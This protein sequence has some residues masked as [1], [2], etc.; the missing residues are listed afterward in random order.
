MNSHVGVEHETTTAR[1]VRWLLCAIV[2]L[3]AMVLG[4]RSAGE[5][6]R[7]AER[8]LVSDGLDGGRLKLF[9]GKSVVVK[10]ARPIKR[11]SIPDG[12]IAVANVVS[13][14]NVL[15]TGK[16]SGTSQ[17]VL[18]DEQ[19]RTQMIDVV[20][21][22]DIGALQEQY[23]TLF[24]ESKIEA[25]SANGTILLKGRAANAQ[26]AEQAV[27]L[28]APYGKVLNLIDVAGG[29]QVMLQVRFA[30][31]SRSATSA[32]GINLF[33][34][35][36]SF[37]GGSNIG[38][39]SPITSLL[40]NVTVGKTPAFNG[41]NLTDAH[42]ISPSV[43]LYGATQ[44]GNVYLEAFVEALRQNNLL[45]I[46]AE[47]NLLAMSGE[48]ASFLA[49][50]EFPIPIAQ[51]GAGSGGNTAITVQFKEF[52]VKL[53]F[54]PVVLGDGRIRLKVAP[55]VSDIDFTTAVK[56]NGFVIPGLS[57]RRVSTTIELAEG[58]TFAIAGLLNHTVSANKDATPLLG[59]LPVIGSLFRS[60]RYMRKETELVVLV[61]P[62]VVSA[63]NPGEVP[64]MPGE[65]WRHPKETDL[66]GKGDLGGTNG[67]ANA[68]APPATAP[69]FFGQHGFT[70]AAK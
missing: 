7:P 56:F 49:G 10:A 46:L 68:T 61:T 55:E 35:S 9:T 22:L 17:L 44:I 63:M 52:G 4:A 34:V 14:T 67:A 33:A 16:K 54:V 8:A 43:T 19:D 62:K 38:Q 25:A 47:P 40:K 6:I 53:N 45:R 21:Q 20:V 5:E 50:G 58:Q 70:P 60:V 2:A 29:Q 28:A 69:K 37:V 65:S 30:E 39:I 11:V 13:P 15:V 51:G 31:V 26:V 3:V 57:Q 42:S 32:L 64:A 24:P 66:F 18:W 59:D 41:T 36:G 12:D 23:K 48:E 1:I 27:A